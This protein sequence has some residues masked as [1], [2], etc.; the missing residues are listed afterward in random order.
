MITLKPIPYTTNKA[1][2]ECGN[3]FLLTDMFYFDNLTT[4]VKSA[5][6]CN[7]LQDDN[8]AESMKQKLITVYKAHI[9]SHSE[10]IYSYKQ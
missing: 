9:D 6:G 10:H 2:Q 4:Q 8:L 3:C 1:R 5:K 7:Q